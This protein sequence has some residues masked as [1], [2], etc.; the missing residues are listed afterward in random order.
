MVERQCAKHSRRVGTERQGRRRCGATDRVRQGVGTFFRALDCLPLLFS[1]AAATRRWNEA[2]ERG[3]R[4]GKRERE[5]WNGAALDKRGKG[6]SRE[7]ATAR[8]R[9]SHQKSRK[10]SRARLGSCEQP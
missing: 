4:R 10:V 7:R 9:T 8:G 2:Q 6:Q 5:Q 3:E 1:L